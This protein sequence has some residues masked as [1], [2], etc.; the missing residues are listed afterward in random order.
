MASGSGRGRGR[1]SGSNNSGGKDQKYLGTIQ[2]DLFIRQQGQS[3]TGSSGQP[4]KCFANFIPIEMTQS[5][6]SIYQ[7][8]VEFEPTVDS[9][10]NREKMLR[11]NNVTDEIGHHFVFDG[12]ILYLKEEWEQNQMIEVQHPIDRSLICIRFKQTNRFLV[13]DPQTINIFNTI[14]RRSFDALQLT[15]LG[16]NYFNWGDSRAVPDYNM[17]ILPGYETAIRMYEENFMLCV[18]NRFKM[19]REESMYIL[20]HK[21]LRSCQ[22]NPQRVQ[23]KMN[24]MYGGT[25]IITRYNN[26][27]HRYTRLD[28]SISP[29]SEFVKDGQS[30]TLKEYFKNQY[31]IEITV[32]DQPIIISEGKPKQPGE[33]PQVSY[34]VPELCFPTG[35]TDEMRKDFKMMKEIAKH[36]RMSPQ[37]RLVESRKLIVDLSKNEKVMECFKYW[38]ISLGQDLANVQARVLKSEPL[39]GKKTYEGKQAEWA[40]GVKECGIY[41]GSNMTNWIVIGPGSGN[42]GLLSQKFIEEARRLGKILQVQLGEPMCVPIRGISPNDYLEGVKG[43][44]KQV[45]GEDI[46]MLVVMLADDNK[47]RYDSLKKFLCVECPIPNQCVNLRTLAGKSKDGGENKNLGSIVLKIV[48]QMICKTGGALWKVNIPLKNTM[49]V[50]YDLYHDSTLK[51]KTVGACVST[52]SNDFTQFYSQTRP[53]E[54]P[55]QLGNNLTHFVRKALKQY[56]DSNDQTLP[57]RL[58]LYRDGAGDGQIPYIKNTEVKLVRDACDAVTDKAAELSNKVQEKI[59]LA[60]IIV[61][62]RVNMRILKQGSSLDNAI[63]PQPGTVV[64]TTVTRPERMDFYLVP[65]FVNQGTVTPV[66]YNI[67]HDDTDLGPDKHQQLAFKLCHLYYNWQGTVRVPAPCQYAHKLA[68]LTAQSL[69]DDAN[70]CLRDKLFFL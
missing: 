59:K 24:E 34:I 29:L 11:D 69:H 64:D 10:A 48:L 55:T 70:G 38:G 44:I 54:N 39:Q 46:H 68:F 1:G 49:I 7:Y 15:Q 58:I 47:T 17:S 22:N 20:F 13:D 43:A 28:Y 21:E 51:G 61:T 26:K 50:G 36:T 60:F 56:Y 57:S 23:E 3:K 41:R 65:Q 67:I 12:M 5:D 9:K 14:I 30:I 18:E 16:R 6:Y 42:S 31:G 33:P 45:D 63:N 35:L 25:T 8:H 53:H 37:Q 19:V 32:D 62:K 40:R 4:Q 66:S 2:P 52:T 27:L